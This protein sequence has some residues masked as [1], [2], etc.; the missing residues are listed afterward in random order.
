[1]L[2]E[3]PL[4]AYC[5]VTTLA[6]GGRG[7]NAASFVLGCFGSVSSYRMRL[8]PSVRWLFRDCF[9]SVGWLFRDRLRR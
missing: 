5:H 6:R 7:A 4:V 8:F 9:P 2:E 3:H 1:M